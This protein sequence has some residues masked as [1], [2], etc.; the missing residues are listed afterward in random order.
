MGVQVVRSPTT[1]KINREKGTSCFKNLKER[2]KS[3]LGLFLLIKHYDV[4]VA[5]VVAVI[6]PVKQK[7]HQMVLISPVLFVRQPKIR[8]TAL[9]IL[10]LFLLKHIGVEVW[11]C[12]RCFLEHRQFSTQPGQADK[13]PSPGSSS[14]LQCPYPALPDEHMN[15][16]LMPSS[17]VLPLTQALI[18]H[19]SLRYVYLGL[20]LVL[21]TVSIFFS[22]AVLWV[23][24]KRSSPQDETLSVNGER[25]ACGTKSRKD[26]FVNSDQLIQSTYWPEKETRL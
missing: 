14:L 1:R 5:A 10:V 15:V 4:I 18:N 25:G 19:F 13:L 9:K 22:V 16:S 8:V 17:R 7:C 21:G 23:L 12:L 26:N 20:T 3:Q 11:Q 6:M 2:A 24:R